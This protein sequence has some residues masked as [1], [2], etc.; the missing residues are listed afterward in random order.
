MALA[1][2]YTKSSI[3]R[4]K[5]IATET[6]SSLGAR[7]VDNFSI[8]VKLTPERKEVSVYS[9]LEN[10]TRALVTSA[11][12]SALWQALGEDSSI[13]TPMGAKE[14]MKTLSKEGKISEN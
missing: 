5:T 2:P 10:T 13:S 4:I 3:Q 12:I 6:L 8:S 7:F 9:S 14:I 1:L 11:Y